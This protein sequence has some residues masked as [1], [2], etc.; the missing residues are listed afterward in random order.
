[1]SPTLTQT[2]YLRMGKRFSENSPHPAHRR[3]CVYSHARQLDPV[4]WQELWENNMSVA[5]TKGWP[6]FCGGHCPSRESADDPCMP[7]RPAN[8]LD[9]CPCS[10]L[11]VYTPWA[12]CLQA[13][14]SG[15]MSTSFLSY[16]QH[17]EGKGESSLPWIPICS[18]IPQ[19][20]LYSK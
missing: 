18:Q 20:H 2:A 1:M 4:E 10:P 14:F 19:K 3:M 17:M 7:P 13:M 9:S 16:P 11:P 5:S 6:V 12:F 8:Q 15:S